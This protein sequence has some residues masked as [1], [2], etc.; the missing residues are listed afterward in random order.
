MSNKQK[1]G[2]STWD[3]F[4]RLSQHSEMGCLKT[5]GN[6]HPTVRAFGPTQDGLKHWQFI[7]V[8]NVTSKHGTFSSCI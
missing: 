5:G 8:G 7:Q 3:V 1:Y 2:I 4:S 6:V